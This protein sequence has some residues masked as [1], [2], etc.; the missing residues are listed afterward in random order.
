MRASRVFSVAMFEDDDGG[1]TDIELAWSAV[2]RVF[3]GVALRFARGARQAASALARAVYNPIFG[4]ASGP[5]EIP[6]RLKELAEWL[7]EQSAAFTASATVVG[8]DRDVTEGT[9][10]LRF[11]GEHIDLPIALVME[12]EEDPRGRS[13]RLPRDASAQALASR[14]NCTRAEREGFR[15]SLRTWPSTLRSCASVTSMP[16]LP[17]SRP[18]A[19]SATER[20]KCTPALAAPCMNFT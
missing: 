7:S 12:R 20:E 14:A 17:A 5:N 11:N 8:I 13:P 4:A 18:M 1:A 15:P 19:A 9:L 6:T 3:P 2:R 10:S 16:S